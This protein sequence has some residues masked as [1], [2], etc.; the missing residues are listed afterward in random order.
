MNDETELLTAQATL[1]DEADDVV[2]ALGLDTSL[3]MFGDA[4]RVG[5][6]ALGLMVVRDIDLTV[7]CPRLD[8]STR[9]AVLQLGVSLGMNDRVR[10]VS[11]RNDT[12]HWNT[13]PAYPDGLYL[14]I[15]YRKP[16]GE[17]WNIDIWFVDEP[18]RQPDLEHL[19]TLAPRVTPEARAAILRVK[20]ELVRRGTYASIRSFAVYT[21]VLDGGV[22]T[23]DEF[24]A[25]QGDGH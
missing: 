12:T 3:A 11:F 4:T 21:A 23:V 8:T 22:R 20:R 19:R 7:A 17:D 16:A 2:A 13:D 10:A 1:R 18:E 9:H 25:W 24:D 5:S 14:G 6:S 15:K